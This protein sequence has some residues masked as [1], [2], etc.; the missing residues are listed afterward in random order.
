MLLPPLIGGA[1]VLCLL[2]AVAISFGQGAKGGNPLAPTPQDALARQLT[3]DLQGPLTPADIRRAIKPLSERQR[4]L[5]AHPYYALYRTARQHFGVSTFLVAAIHYQETG[6]GEAPTTLAGQPAW[7][8]H[9]SAATQI[10]RPATTPIA[11]GAT[12][13]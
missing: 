5:R 1:A 12:P 2:L 8:R 6:F 4:I 10:P 11:P 9:R 7:Q 3:L 13:P